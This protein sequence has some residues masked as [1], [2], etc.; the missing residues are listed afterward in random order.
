MDFTK[1][2][3]DEWKDLL[4]QVDDIRYL[5]VKSGGMATKT[6]VENILMARYKITRS[7]AHSLTNSAENNNVRAFSTCPLRWNTYTTQRPEPNFSDWPEIDLT[8]D[9]VKDKQDD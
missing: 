2:S 4:S 1:M 5:I 8:K 6:N 3:I 7:D 9:S